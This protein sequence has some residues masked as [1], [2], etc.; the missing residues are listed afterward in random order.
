MEPEPEPGEER[1]SEEE[2]SSRGTSPG[3]FFGWF[4]GNRRGRS[5]TPEPDEEEG[6][7]SLV[8]DS[9][10]IDASGVVSAEIGEVEM[11]NRRGKKHR[12]LSPHADDHDFDPKTTSAL[13]THEDSTIQTLRNY[14][15][16]PYF[17]EQQAYTPLIMR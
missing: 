13:L 16:A 14:T 2:K 6:R 7:S 10:S 3:G 8:V 15:P 5:R 4:G 1:P 17:E 9:Y 11:Q 12:S